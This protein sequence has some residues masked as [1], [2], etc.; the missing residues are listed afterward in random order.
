GIGHRARTSGAGR[1]D[2]LRSRPADRSFR[3]RGA[4]DSDVG[5]LRRARRRSPR[6]RRSGHAGGIGSCLAALTL[7]RPLA[8]SHRALPPSAARAE[9]APNG[10]LRAGI[11][12]GNFIL[13][14][15]DPATGEPH[16]VA[17]DLARELAQRLGVPLE[18]VPYTSV[19]AMV[20]AAPTGAWSI[21]FLG[22]DPA[23]EGEISFSAAYL[24]IEATYLVP[25]GPPLRAV[26]D[27]DRQGV[28][29]AAPAPAEHGPGLSRRLQS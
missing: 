2:R 5:R 20:D 10:T 1:R 13:A 3:Q 14:T 7:A 27:G 19:A 29:V 6:G 8:S 23:R 28:R 26:A 4:G 24:E 21:A 15:K 17:I 18:L 25:A 22:I 9:L 11:N 16:G 12:Y